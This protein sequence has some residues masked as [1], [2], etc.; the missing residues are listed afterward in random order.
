ML[1]ERLSNRIHT[2]S[3]ICSMSSESCESTMMR[4][5]REK[6][7]NFID[8]VEGHGRDRHAISL[9]DAHLYR[10]RRSNGEP[11]GQRRA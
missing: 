3:S 11:S 5:K 2:R 1:Y 4:E 10:G 7:A 6:K 9:Q 8:L